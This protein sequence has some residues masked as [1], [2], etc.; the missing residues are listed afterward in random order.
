MAQGTMGL[1]LVT[2]RITIRIQ[3]SEVRNPHSLD[4]RKSYQQILM[5]FCGELG[6]WTRDQLIT[7]W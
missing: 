1:I 5:K 6:V 3:E 7:F 2:I 4:Y